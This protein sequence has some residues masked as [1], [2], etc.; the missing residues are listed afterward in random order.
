MKY[1]S[2]FFPWKIWSPNQK[3]TSWIETARAISHW[4]IYSFPSMTKIWG[5]Q[6]SAGGDERWILNKGLS[7]YYVI[8]GT[9]PLDDKGWGTFLWWRNTWTIIAWNVFGSFP[10]VCLF[11]CVFGSF[12]YNQNKN[13][14]YFVYVA[15]SLMT[16][17]ITIVGTGFIAC[18]QPKPKL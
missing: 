17:T 10:N 14:L 8:K 7:S 13:T 9:S 6:R 5:G 15:A 18:L 11:I 3:I 2:K 4:D 12:P 1:F 16:K